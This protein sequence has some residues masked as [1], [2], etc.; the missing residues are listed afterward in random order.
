MQGYGINSVLPSLY[1]C[2]VMIPARTI[3]DAVDLS[4]LNT[5][6]WA[7]ILSLTLFFA[8]VIDLARTAVWIPIA[9]AWEVCEGIRRALA[10]FAQH[11]FALVSFPGLSLFRMF[12][13]SAAKWTK[14]LDGAQQLRPEKE[15]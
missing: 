12:I 1:A 11:I 13:A 8:D 5:F 2:I 10:V 6:S 15:N 7:I 9:R 4:L 3:S 14:F